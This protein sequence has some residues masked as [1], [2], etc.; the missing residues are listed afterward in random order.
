MPAVKK[1]EHPNDRG[2]HL[3]SSDV[4]KPPQAGNGRGWFNR[5]LAAVE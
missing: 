1:P 3:A 5:F 4:S 2:F